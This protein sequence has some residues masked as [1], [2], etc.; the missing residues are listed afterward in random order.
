MN[1]EEIIVWIS[2]IGAFTI[3]VVASNQLAEIFQKIKLPLITGFIVIGVLSGPYV[4]KM[5]PKDLV[6]L[7]FIN[8][9]SLGFIAFAAGGEM[10]LK[11]IRDKIR[12]ISIMSAAQF[13]ITFILSFVLIM[14]FANLIPFMQGVE[15][16]I[17]IAISLLISTI[18]I[19]RSP[20]SVIAIINELRAKGPFTKVALGVTIIKDIFVI[21]L[22]AL[23][24]SIASVLVEGKEF[25]SLEL[26]IVFIGLI[27]S[28]AMGFVYGK[29]FEL[30][31]KINKNSFLDLIIVL[32]IGWSMFLLSSFVSDISE[33]Y[34]HIHIH[35][36]ALLIG[37]IASFYI[38]NY[39]KYRKYLQKIVEEYGNYIYVVF[40]TFIGASLDID[41]LI[42]YWAVAFLLF[43][44]RLFAII[45]AS[46][47]GSIIL[48]DSKKKTLLSWTPYITQAGVSIGLIMIVAAHF[49][50]FGKEF[51]AILI[52]VI[53]INQFVG[54][55]LMKFSILN[56]GESHVKS[57]NHEFDYHKDV[58]IIGLEGKAIVLG[59]M[60]K[61]QN[62]NVT[63]ITDR[64]DLDKS[65]CTELK[66]IEVAEINYE[67]LKAAD[68]KSADSVVILK[69]EIEAYRISEI[70]Y[71]KFGTP[72]V[73]VRLTK[74]DNIKNFKDLNVIVVEPASAIIT[75]LEHFIRSPN[76]TSILMGMEEEHNTEDIEVLGRDIHGRALRDIGFPLGVLVISITRNHH[77][78]LP[79][80]Y[81]RLRLHDVVTVIGSD[82][83]L[84]KVRT[85][86]QV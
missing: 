8:D 5:L 42:K 27:L 20:A 61:K 36:E 39:S 44:I 32:I 3:I 67:T 12:D 74:R 18:F 38:T 51:A 6:D 72:N 30:N 50:G 37:I 45:I 19:A 85:K 28:I 64:P 58:F 29:L 56:I 31:F 78:V 55:P 70:I 43:G 13:F 54:P 33:K 14:L 73:V 25:N 71:E 48:K 84:E 66:I 35:L 26:L 75:L 59:K 1:T 79:Q 10:Y 16:N 80:G 76:A 81:T 49:V 46:I 2:I 11:E 22:F 57:K 53:V 69:E 24:F 62:Y 9:I 83:E 65:N 82:N 77:V 68:L 41:V 40:F 52:A 17:K 60:L 7:G 15:L 34:L 86:L 47:T 4:L 63:I 21:I 23:T